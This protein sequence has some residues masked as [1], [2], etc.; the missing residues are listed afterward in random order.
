MHEQAAAVHVGD[1]AVVEV[2]R[3]GEVRLRRALQGNPLQP[4]VR[5]EL[6]APRAGLGKEGGI[7]LAVGGRRVEQAARPVGVSEALLLGGDGA[8]G[9][10]DPSSFH[11]FSGYVP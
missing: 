6:P 7:V 9:G 1:D 4:V 11:S 8:G 10:A 2:P 5:A 3:D